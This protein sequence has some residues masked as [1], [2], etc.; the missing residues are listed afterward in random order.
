[1][2][3]PYVIIDLDIVETK[4]REL[5]E[6]LHSTELCYAVKANPGKP[7]IERLAAL[8]AS[9]DVA[10]VPEIDLVLSCGVEPARIS[11][12]NTI[13]KQRD[14][15]YA[16]QQGITRFTVDTMSELHKVLAEAPQAEVCVRLFH[17]C[18]GADW[19]LSKKF[20]CGFADAKNILIAAG[21]AGCTTGISFHV[22]SHHYNCASNSLL[23]LL[24]NPLHQ[25]L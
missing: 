23:K 6:A 2:Q 1:M 9:F 22:G 17:D 15:A 13:K 5:S 7:V 4:F 24:K 3:T 21:N 10:S 16:A 20:G 11:F 14:I 8:G 25:S 12:G 18:E 19:P